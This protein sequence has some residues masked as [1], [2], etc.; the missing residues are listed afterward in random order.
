MPA[1]RWL[2]ALVPFASLAGGVLIDRRMRAQEPLEMQAEWLTRAGRYE[3]AKALYLRRLQR[4]PITI[5]LIVARIDVQAL[6]RVLPPPRKD[7]E[8]ESFGH[9]RSERI[10][11]HA[12][13]EVLH[14][15]FFRDGAPAAL[16]NENESFSA[17]RTGSPC[18]QTPGEVS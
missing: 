7:G 16:E 3:Q 9:R 5:P 1:L 4:G 2:L 17:S 14:R 15:L 18:P 13:H 11:D 10:R 6:G 12:I 8:L